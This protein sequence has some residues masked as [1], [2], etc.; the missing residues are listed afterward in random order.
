MVVFQITGFNV[1]H[2]DITKRKQE[3]PVLQEEWNTTMKIMLGSQTQQ[4]GKMMYLN[5][6][7]QSLG[8]DQ[9]IYMILKALSIPWTPNDDSYSTI[10]NLLLQL[11]IGMRIFICDNDLSIAIAACVSAQMLKVKSPQT[12]Y[13]RDTGKSLAVP[14][15]SPHQ[16]CFKLLQ[17]F[18]KNVYILDLETE[19][20]QE[21][22]QTI[23][24]AINTKESV[25]LVNNF[26]SNLTKLKNMT[27]IRFLLNSILMDN[28]KEGEVFQLA[29]KITLVKNLS[30]QVIIFSTSPTANLFTVLREYNLY[31]QSV[32]DRIS[33]C[34]EYIKKENIDKQSVKYKQQFYQQQS[35]EYIFGEENSIR[36]R[37]EQIKV[38]DL[39]ITTLVQYTLGMFQ[40]F[41][42]GF[43]L[44]HIY[45]QE[46]IQNIKMDNS[47]IQR[48]QQMTQT[49]EQIN[50]MLLIMSFIYTKNTGMKQLYDQIFGMVKGIKLSQ[51]SREALMNTK[52][53]N[54]DYT[55]PEKMK[56]INTYLMQSKVSQLMFEITN[57]L[58]ATTYFIES[59]SQYHL[60]VYS[61]TEIDLYYD[62]FNKLKSSI[63]PYVDQLKERYKSTVPANQPNISPTA[64]C[65]YVQ[66]P[67][68]YHIKHEYQDFKSFLVGIII[69]LLTEKIFCLFPFEYACAVWLV[70][71]SLFLVLTKL[72]SRNQS[73]SIHKFDSLMRIN[74]QTQD[75]MLRLVTGYNIKEILTE[76]SVFSL[77]KINSDKIQLVDDVSQ[78][79]PKICGMSSQLQNIWLKFSVLAR[80]N[81]ELNQVLPWLVANHAS[82]VSLC[83]S[84]N[85]L[86][87]LI[88]F[89]MEK[90]QQT[91]Q[92]QAKQNK[93]KLIE[94]P[95]TLQIPDASTFFEVFQMAIASQPQDILMSQE[96][97]ANSMSHLFG[98]SPINV[99]K[100]KISQNAGIIGHNNMPGSKDTYFK[101]EEITEF[102]QPSFDL[103]IRLFGSEPGNCS[104]YISETTVQL[105]NLI[106]NSY[107]SIL[108]YNK[109]ESK[110]TAPPI[111][112]SII[113]YDQG[114]AIDSIFEFCHF[115][116]DQKYTTGK[117][118][119]QETLIDLPM[120][121][122]SPILLNAN[123][124]MDGE[125]VLKYII[126]LLHKK[127]TNKK[128]L[129]PI[130]ILIPSSQ[131]QQSLNKYNQQGIQMRD[132][133]KFQHLLKIIYTLALPR[134]T[135]I[136]KPG[137]IYDAFKHIILLATVTVNQQ[138][139]LYNIRLTSTFDNCV[140]TM[141][142]FTVFCLRHSLII[143]R[144]VNESYDDQIIQVIMQLFARTT[145]STNSNFSIKF[146]SPFLACSMADMMF[147]WQD[148]SQ[149]MDQIDQHTQMLADKSAKRI[150]YGIY[151]M[152]DL[153]I[154]NFVVESIQKRFGIDQKIRDRMNVKLE[155]EESL[156]SNE[157]SNQSKSQ[158]ISASRTSTSELSDESGTDFDDSMSMFSSNSKTSK[159]TSKT[160]QSTISTASSILNKFEQQMIVNADEE[161]SV[162]RNLMQAIITDVPIDINNLEK[163]IK[164]KLSDKHRK[165][166]QYC[167]SQPKEL[168]NMILTLQGKKPTEDQPQE[169]DDK[170]EYS[171]VSQPVHNLQRV[172][173]PYV[174]QFR[175]F[176]FFINQLKH[177]QNQQIQLEQSSLKNIIQ[178]QQPTYQQVCRRVCSSE[179]LK[180]LVSE[181]KTKQ[182]VKQKYNDLENLPNLFRSY[183]SHLESFRRIQTDGPSKY[184]SVDELEENLLKSNLTLENN[185]TLGKRGFGVYDSH[186]IISASIYAPVM[187]DIFNF[188]K[189]MNAVS[190]NAPIS[191]QRIVISLATPHKN[192]KILEDGSVDVGKRADRDEKKNQQFYVVLRNFELVG[193]SYDQ[194][195]DTVCDIT[196]ETKQGFIQTFDL[197][198]TSV[199]IDSWQNGYFDEAFNTQYPESHALK[200]NSQYVPIP[201]KIGGYVRPIV[202]LPNKTKVASDEYV[203][204]GAF[205]AVKWM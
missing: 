168:T 7:V 187:G 40:K 170:S 101:P 174:V 149:L 178:L 158:S 121:Q 12:M 9:P 151:Q 130:Y 54:E 39:A 169:Q 76:E 126:T 25:I 114:I 22:Q 44:S 164:S 73:D 15:D 181:L 180:S 199:V 185:L 74:C 28:L 13:Y 83:K 41:I 148:A 95:P 8:N 96:V 63:G 182:Q 72:I 123:P 119:K 50:K 152:M 200:I 124:E 193:L 198:A 33:I 66:Y 68:M 156:D 108:N 48:M 113:Y 52:E 55:E 69:P 176:G 1:V 142:G 111:S 166:R 92:L 122:S 163:T 2:P 27:I 157:L 87:S 56:F 173:V 134:S 188:I 43:V 99:Y 137:S 98:I 47:L 77:E 42:K 29:N 120:L 30:D 139:F 136:Q 129:H 143:P 205:F 21:F 145:Q 128:S 115:T 97:L 84:Q 78:T 201:V 105:Y 132:N 110:T 150:L 79:I 19:F 100:Q 127:Q 154:P 112:L 202:L 20:T 67:L 125:S 104:E 138:A 141:R 153:F 4:Y 18:M 197:V 5:D 175:E 93:D 32:I 131:V 103:M 165:C 109:A 61:V 194:I 81:L 118:L 80:Y 46:E 155:D 94:L 146:N 196:P 147:F 26:G 117:R 38:C 85:M 37:N 62:I 140:V 82:F 49:P 88:Q 36:A 60:P 106:L 14:I 191:R 64:Q 34:K 51:I 162:Y 89:F 86:V 17:D 57:S 35:I 177:Y 53:Q 161:Q 3:L 31:Q 24:T 75:D 159:M 45:T 204:R 172:F 59:L 189:M 70:S 11:Q 179:Q 190:Q 116:I 107:V 90:Q 16:P 10:N 71:S 195:L 192:P 6:V 58:T 91:S 160:Q 183:I 144:Q 135:Y 184:F 186:W 23:I 133:S 167:V 65:L 171:V 102:F 203:K